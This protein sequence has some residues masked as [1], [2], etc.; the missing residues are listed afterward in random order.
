MIFIEP[1]VILSETEGSCVLRR[2]IMTQSEAQ[3]SKRDPSIPRERH[4]ACFRTTQDDN[5]GWGRLQG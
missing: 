4:L 1:L 3:Q 2:V 5:F